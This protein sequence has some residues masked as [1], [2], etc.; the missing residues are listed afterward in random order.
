[1]SSTTFTMTASGP[2]SEY[3]LPYTTE[4]LP[5]QPTPLPQPPTSDFV[6]SAKPGYP[7]DLVPP[8]DYLK[9]ARVVSNN[10][11]IVHTRTLYPNV[12]LPSGGEGIYNDTA[13]NGYAVYPDGSVFHVDMTGMTQ[14]SAVSSPNFSGWVK[15]MDYYAANGYFWGA[16]NVN[17]LN[18]GNGN[19][20]FQEGGYPGSY[21]FRNP[22][23]MLPFYYQCYQDHPSYTALTSDY[24][25]FYG[26]YMYG[27][28]TFSLNELFNIMVSGGLYVKNGS[29]YAPGYSWWGGD[30]I[31]YPYGDIYMVKLIIQSSPPPST[32]TALGETASFDLGSAYQLGSYGYCAGGYPN[33]LEPNVWKLGGSNDNTT[34]YLVDSVSNGN[35][36][37]GDARSFTPSGPSSTT[38]FRYYRWI[39]QAL[40]NG[41]TC[42]MGGF[43]LKN[44]SG[45]V[46]NATV[47]QNNIVSTY[48]GGGHANFSYWINRTSFGGGSE[49]ILPNYNVTY[50]GSNSTTLITAAPASTPGA[51]TSLSASAGN[52]SVS[53][54]FSEGSNGGSSITNYKYSLDGGSTFTA[55]SPAQT[56]SPV[57]ITG[58][59]NGVSYTIQLKAVNSSG[60]GAASASITATPSTVPDAPTNL[61]ASYAGSGAVQITFTPGSDEGSPI[62][63]YQYSLDGGSTFTDANTTADPFNVSGLTNGQ[64]YV[65]EVKSVNANGAGAASSSVGYTAYGPPDAPTNITWVDTLNG[66]ISVSFTSGYNEGDA[67]INYEYSLDGG[68]T[69]TP[70]NPSYSTS[71][72]PI[73]GLNIRT[74]YSLGLRAVNAA[75]SGQSS[76]II[77]MYYMCFLEGTKILCFN[78]ETKQEEY[79]AIETLRK[80]SLVKTV[81]DGYKAIDMIGTS[82]IYNPGNSVR[83]KNR[84]YKCSKEKYPQ[85][86]EDLYITGC[87]S[88]LVKDISEEER[89]E[90]IDYQGKIYIT[91][92]HYRLIAAVDKRAEPH[93]SEGVFNIWHLALENDNYYFNYGIYANGLL[94][95]TSSLRMMKEFSGMDIVQ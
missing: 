94:V 67:I 19:Y 13:G 27:R 91:D 59:T 8:P 93:A 58:L 56:T 69:F 42:Y 39:L 24:N 63:S 25:V 16:S 75:G 70:L 18:V 52:H 15:I 83:S 89:A 40:S 12:N 47:I 10:T 3:A 79:C 22:S 71:P 55:F 33:Y 17:Q 85:L 88:I 76:A 54:S 81:D 21:G 64:Y 60:D 5:N 87:H 6:A 14:G 4:P 92:N 86:T 9:N 77:N 82:K 78:P 28:T 2:Y 66:T 65:I 57:T 44:T 11:P 29:Q 34:W 20:T 7:K 45:N 43:F 26:G 84:L 51:P 49:D 53:I 36:G 46:I 61:I 37:S 30:S 73:S 41:G 80:G 50:N 23:V 74:H 68:N 1:M 32:I 72:I 38:A 31:V 90:L 35:A 48:H 62:T 95:E